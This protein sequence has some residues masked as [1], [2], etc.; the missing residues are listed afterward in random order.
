[1]ADSITF[2]AKTPN[3][4]ALTLKAAVSKGS[5]NATVST[6]N[7][8]WKA[9]D[10]GVTGFIAGVGVVVRGETKTFIPKKITKEGDPRV[11]YQDVPIPTNTIHNAEE[12]F[13]ICRGGSDGASV[14]PTTKKSAAAAQ[15]R[16]PA[17][18]APPI[19][20]KRPTWADRAKH[21]A[22]PSTRNP[23][24]ATTVINGVE[25]SVIQGALF[26]KYLPFTPA[27]TIDGRTREETLAKMIIQREC[28]CGAIDL[29]IAEWYNVLPADTRRQQ[30]Q[31]QAAQ[32]Q[33]KAA[34][35]QTPAAAPAP[36]KG[37]TSEAHSKRNTPA[38][39][40]SSDI[41]SQVKSLLDTLTPETA[42]ASDIAQAASIY[43]LLDHG[44]T[45]VRVRYLILG[46]AV[47][48]APPLGQNLCWL[49]SVLQGAAG[50]I[51]PAQDIQAMLK[52][53]YKPLVKL[54]VDTF[55]EQSLFNLFFARDEGSI[56]VLGQLPWLEPEQLMSD[57]RHMLDRSSTG[58]MG[59]RLHHTILATLLMSDIHVHIG[60]YVDDA[61]EEQFA[62]LTPI[63][64]TVTIYTPA[65]M[66]RGVS[67]R[68]IH[69]KYQD[70]KEH[71]DTI[72]HAAPVPFDKPDALGPAALLERAK[73]YIMTMAELNS[74]EAMRK[75]Y[76]ANYDPG[77]KHRPI[78]FRKPAKGGA[79]DLDAEEESAPR[80]P[81]KTL[82]EDF[83]EFKQVI[84]QALSQLQKQQAPPANPDPASRPPEP[85]HPPTP[86]VR[87]S[88]GSN[89]APAAGADAS[90]ARSPDPPAADEQD[91]SGGE[92]ANDGE[93][94]A[95]GGP[96]GG[97]DG[98]QRP[99][100]A[101]T[102]SIT[103]AL[104]AAKELAGTGGEVFLTTFQLSKF[105]ATDGGKQVVFYE[106]EDSE[107]GWKLVKED[108]KR[109]FSSV[110]LASKPNAKANAIATRVCQ[111]LLGLPSIQRRQGI[112]RYVAMLKTLVPGFVLPKRT[113]TEA[114]FSDSDAAEVLSDDVPVVPLSPSGSSQ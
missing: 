98:S 85:A 52:H 11:T 81:R 93:A 110:V 88:P 23:P 86:P 112:R 82:A 3:G 10:S 65:G 73:D 60:A 69:I 111:S 40:G 100:D 54:L 49:S 33:Q 43:E 28:D 17:Q 30:P 89:A 1:M 87:T 67:K 61:T 6:M 77:N 59:G 39:S 76:G 101:Q 25:L 71:F 47:V 94:G 83:A 34:P 50:R 105:T 31:K 66:R 103:A 72:L 18:P 41:A 5:G 4:T 19:E 84:L 51:L 74:G 12:I 53:G 48:H 21:A 29:D 7:V 44:P 99:S 55:D 70:G 35:Q 24:P 26:K 36:V 20:D 8:I 37:R 106:M 64:E 92:D 57:L 63:H 102:A 9:K 68:E 108:V 75:L 45:R 38:P 114:G 32:S 14:K 2:T 109:Q 42:S 79:I 91:A 15:A 113:L 46:W 96:V 97:G 27:Q 22:P 16:P 56:A 107:E 104:A 13:V 90:D 95:A 80:L 62:K 58:G 78:E